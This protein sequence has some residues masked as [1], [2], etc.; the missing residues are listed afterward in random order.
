[1][2]K[3]GSCGTRTVVGDATRQRILDFVNDFWCQKYSPPS[4]RDVMAALEI[5]STSPISYHVH[6]MEELGLVKLND[7]NRMIPLWVI[8]AIRESEHGQ[9]TT[10]NL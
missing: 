6:R 10:S 7:Q 8:Q 4:I 3:K 9:E 1:M 5:T 2:A